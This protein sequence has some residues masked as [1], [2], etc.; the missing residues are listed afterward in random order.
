MLVAI[1][2]MTMALKCQRGNNN[3]KNNRVTFVGGEEGLGIQFEDQAPPTEVFDMGQDPFN[4]ELRFVNKGEKLIPKDKVKVTLSGLNPSDFGKTEQDF[5]LN[6]I[7]Q[8]I[9]PVYLSSQG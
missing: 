2:L 7:S 3:T 1:A 6:G 4:V 9:E 8:D 5:I